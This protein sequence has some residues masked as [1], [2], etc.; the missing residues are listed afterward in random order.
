MINIVERF[1]QIAT[2][3]AQSY[4]DDEFIIRGLWRIDL[5]FR[6]N[7][8]ER[9]FNYTVV[10]AQTRGQGCCY[11]HSEDS[12]FL[13]SLIG[14]DARTVRPGSRSAEIAILDAV[15]ASFPTTPTNSFVLDGYAADKAMQRTE[16]VINEVLQQ[17]RDVDGRPP[18]VVNVGVV[19]NFVKALLQHGINVKATDL[20]ATLIGTAINGVKVEGGEH[21]L[22][23]I[24][25]S[26]VALITGMTLATSALED[27]IDTAKRSGTKLV[28]FAETGANFA[29]VYC[30]TLGIDVVVSE[31]FPFY[32]FQG[33]SIIKV[34][35]QIPDVAAPATTLVGATHT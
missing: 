1:R 25:E 24:A 3:K 19:G 26:D 22:P 18:Q 20:E 32:I 5:L 4:H 16:I 12:V 31:P 2:E 13:P 33:R 29:E 34:Y 7:I 23:L 27:I 28:M 11:C 21:T 10:S 8:N 6:P 35:R 30:N 15:F 17:V 14:Q 9:T